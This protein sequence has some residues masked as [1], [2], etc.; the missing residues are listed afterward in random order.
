[1]R[2][3]ITLSAVFMLFLSF[4]FAQKKDDKVISYDKVDAYVKKI[5]LYKTFQI[6]TLAAYLSAGASRPRDKARAIYD[7]V[8]SNITYDY[9]LLDSLNSPFASVDMI[10]TQ[11]PENVLLS[12]KAVC[13]GYADL[14]KA[15]ADRVGLRAEV[16]SGAVKDGS[17]EVPRI[18]HAWNVV[19]IATEWEL[20]D[21]TWGAN[22]DGVINEKYFFTIPEDMI[23]D[24]LPFDPMWQLTINPLPLS[25]FKS[26]D[27]KTVKKLF[28][29]SPK[30]DFVYKDTI[31]RYFRLDTLMRLYKSSD[32][33][34]RF[35]ADNEYVTFEV[36][37]ANY[38]RY[39]QLSDKMNQRIA[40]AIENR[41][42]D[43]DSTRFET[44]IAAK[45]SYYQK[46]LDCYKQIKD[47]VFQEKVK[48][49]IY[50]SRQIEGLKNHDRGYYFASVFYSKQDADSKSEN[51]LSELER[52]V[53]YS[54]KYFKSSI[55][56]FDTLVETKFKDYNHNALFHQ[57]Y[58]KKELLMKNILFAGDLMDSGEYVT[59]NKKKVQR[60]LNAQQQCYKDAFPLV[61]RLEKLDTSYHLKQ[62]FVLLK[63]GAD[64]LALS[65]ESST[66]FWGNQDSKNMDLE[67][68]QKQEKIY[69]KINDKIIA[70]KKELAEETAIENKELYYKNIETIEMSNSFSI[71]A[72]SL[73][74]CKLDP[75][76]T[77]E[78]FKLLV[79]NAELYTDA[80]EK[81]FKK[82]KG[83]REIFYTTNKQFI[84][85]ARKII[86]LLKK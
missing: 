50:T 40:N 46:A 20:I 73:Y 31:L 34:L 48:K 78:Q 84:E 41:N 80:A 22:A 77:Q 13:Q 63:F 45:W 19:K 62:S 28:N 23:V 25:V 33:M 24:H 52:Y 12:R 56:A 65:F 10:R 74:R 70:M 85:N 64:L 17:G 61:P 66:E 38:F 44:K 14:Y 11:S 43:M 4:I 6:D 81:I 79:A 55:T 7:W 71:A 49:G 16:V 68:T 30:N 37:K 15:L 82:Q 47:D 21:A 36:G 26:S 3:K 1:M 53:D 35:N 69:Y 9:T 60:I 54:F 18:G 8:S 59:K 27:D 32:R 57:V 39:I 72:A 86:Q 5:P 51:G 75:S 29:K 67:K 76:L 2:L 58:T 83:Q 42:I